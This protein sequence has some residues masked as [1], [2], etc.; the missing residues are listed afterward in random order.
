M[1]TSMLLQLTIPCV[2][3]Q[4]S[5]SCPVLREM[6]DSKLRE[7][8]SVQ[9]P[10]QGLDDREVRMPQTGPYHQ[11]SVFFEILKGDLLIFF[12]G[13]VWSAKFPW[14]AHNCRKAPI[15]TKSLRPAQG[16]CYRRGGDGE[17]GHD[18]QQR[19]VPAGKPGN[20]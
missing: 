10:K 16:Q 11:K 9:L 3:K 13:L 20:H 2:C 7:K 8:L 1:T 4:I 17:E 5:A 12:Q 14:Q 19:A 15:Q 18:G 6:V